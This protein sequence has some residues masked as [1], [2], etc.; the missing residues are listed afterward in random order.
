MFDKQVPNYV[1]AFIGLI[2]IILLS[3]IMFDYT[4]NLGN[5]VY[6][7]YL[8]KEL[9][10]ILE[11][12][13]Y[14]KIAYTAIAKKMF[15]DENPMVKPNIGI[16]PA[17]IFGTLFFSVWITNYDPFVT[18]VN[19]V[20]AIYAFYLVYELFKYRKTYTNKVDVT[21]EEINK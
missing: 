12:N 20:I 14:K 19:F 15:L 8:Q 6:R 3:Q 2:P 16:L 17:I 1:F 7:S 9:N 21:L 11:K 18:I 10:K 4:R 5:Q 13:N